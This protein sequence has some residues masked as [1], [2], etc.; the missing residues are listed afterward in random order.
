MYQADFSQSEFQR[1]RE[2][3]YQAIGDNA[4]ALIC[5]SE[6]NCDHNIF[7]QNNDFYYVCGVEVPHAYILLDGREKTTT[8][9]LSHQTKEQQEKEGAILSAEIAETCCELTGVDTCLGIESLAKHL[10]GVETLF[11][12]IRQAE[13]PAMS[14][15]T[16]QRAQQEVFSDP[17]DGRLNRTSHIVQLLQKRLL[18]TRIQDLSPV[19]NELRIVKSEAEL[20]L[21]RMAGKIT[22]LGVIEAMRN[23]RPG[24][25]EYQ[26]EAAMRYHFL[27]NGAR[28]AGY[29]AIIAGGPNAWY[30]HYNA[31]NCPLK[32]GDL[33]LVDGAPDYHYYTSDIGRMWPV[34]GKYTPVQ[35]ELYGFIVEYHKVFLSL[36]RPGVTDE[37]I[38]LEAAKEMAPVVKR[39][40]F[41]KEIYRQAAERCLDFP[42][43]MSHSVGMAVHDVGHYRG[44]IL[45]P[46]IVLALD[47]QLIIPEE[48]LYIRV[49][50]TVVVTEDGVENLTVDA[51]L[52]LEDVEQFMKDEGILQHYP[53][54]ND[55]G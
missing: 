23:T 50:D 12:P 27:L 44:T 48:K 29:R 21:M 15:D 24:V 41:S 43:H 3:I 51:P 37:D 28:D 53:P 47:P 34:N 25:M 26:L 40:H 45:K 52:E 49:E 30:G 4:L 55:R 36:I 19:L 6:K 10:E 20:K 14:W 22:A 16:L 54:L 13:G 42:Y 39:T 9:F 11:T 31:N 46:G 35:K 33:V 1:R 17:W 7:R 38:R 5:G 2:A 32:D 8:V 18:K